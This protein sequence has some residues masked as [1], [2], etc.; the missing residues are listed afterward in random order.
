MQKIREIKDALWPKVTSTETA[1]ISLKNASHG[2][3]ALAGITSILFLLLNYKIIFYIEFVFVA[4]LAVLLLKFKSR[5]VSIVLLIWS[6]V[7]FVSTLDNIFFPMEGLPCG[8][9][10]VLAFIAILVSIT[11]IRC[12]WFLN[13]NKIKALSL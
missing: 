2:F 7:A 1:E 6:C 5:V 13:K 8:R 11:S 3:L 12:T 10:I 4:I 9:N